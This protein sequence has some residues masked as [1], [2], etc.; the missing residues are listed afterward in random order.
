V[1]GGDAGAEISG[2]AV[3][4]P[5]T[6]AVGDR[7]ADRELDSPQAATNRMIAEKTTVARTMVVG[8]GISRERTAWS[9]SVGT[10]V[11]R[12][13]AHHQPERHQQS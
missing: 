11:A 10:C 9:G 4:G 13:T 3:A 8:L 1:T 5:A 2:G 6:D 12:H 7:F